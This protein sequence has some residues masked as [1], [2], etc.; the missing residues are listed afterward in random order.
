VIVY[1][2]NSEPKQNTWC[3]TRVK[4]TEESYS[5]SSHMSNC[6]VKHWMKFSII[7]YKRGK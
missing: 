2:V 3:S 6:S 4:Q 7:K 5:S 1:S